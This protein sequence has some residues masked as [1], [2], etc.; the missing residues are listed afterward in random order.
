LPR[1]CR[2]ALE[3]SEAF[4]DVA[5]EAR[6]ALLAVRDDVN[7]DLGLP[8]HDLTDGL[9]HQPSVRIAIVRLRSVLGRQDGDE[10]VRP[11]QA[12]DVRREDP[13]RAPLHRRSECYTVPANVRP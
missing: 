3:A 2:L 4:H 12:A 9:A 6:L 7:A 13:L 1:R 11:R 8:A 10:G 5:K